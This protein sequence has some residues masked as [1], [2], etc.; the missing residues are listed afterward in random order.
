MPQWK[1]VAECS[2]LKNGEG[3]TVDCF[4]KAIALFNDGGHFKAVANTCPH[5]GGS[6]GDGTLKNHCVV[7]PL[8]QWTFHLDSGENTRNPEVKLHVYPTKL[9]GEEILIYA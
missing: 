7:C 3:K 8:H 2:E 6:L 9:E 1:K 4:G 5:R